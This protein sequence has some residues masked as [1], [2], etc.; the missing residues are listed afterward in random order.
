MSR[1]ERAWKFKRV[2]SQ[3]EEPG[4]SSWNIVKRQV[5]IGSF[6]RCNLTSEG[7][8]V[9][10]FG[11][12]LRHMKTENNA[13]HCYENAVLRLEP[14]HQL[15]EQR[16]GLILSPAIEFQPIPCNMHGCEC[17]GIYNIKYHNELGFFLT[18]RY[19]LAILKV[20]FW[21]FLLSY[22]S[23]SRQSPKETQWI[24]KRYNVTKQLQ[25]WR[26]WKWKMEIVL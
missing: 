9:F 4:P 13:H 3:K 14:L 21:N 12:L 25:Q 18:R 1:N 8:V 23:T 6:S 19:F 17:L 10:N 2:L 11:I 24:A 15:A 5:P 26:K 20:E 22:K 7:K 16:G